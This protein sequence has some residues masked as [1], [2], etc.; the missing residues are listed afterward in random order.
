MMSD[1][2]SSGRAMADLAILE[3][4]YPKEISTESSATFNGN[5]FPLIFTLAL[6]M[7]QILENSSETFGANITMEYVE[8]YPSTAIE[9]VSYRSHPKFDKRLIESVVNAVRLT[10]KE[11]MENS[12]ECGIACCAVAINKWLECIKSIDQDEK[13]IDCSVQMNNHKTV[14]DNICWITSENT[15]I[16]R[17]SVFQ[18][19]CCM[20]SDAGMVNRAIQKLLMS[21]SKI[22]RATHNMFAYR[23]SVLKED[24]IEILVHDND[25]DGEDGAGSRLAQLLESRREDGV[26]ILVSRWYGG[27]HLGP[28]RFA[29]IVNVAR[30]LLDDCKK[31]GNFVKK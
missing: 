12:E 17:K 19:H 26:L 13:L 18:A 28:K 7:S 2:E 31:R 11:G 30:D 10:A 20:V 6:P 5:C 16:D 24:G 15:L 22:Q 27:V 29:H 9:I 3:A 23:F 14:D 4:A 1:I 25:D 8:G 21:S